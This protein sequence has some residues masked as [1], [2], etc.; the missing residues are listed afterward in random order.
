MQAV[1]S[2]SLPTGVGSG[3]GPVRCCMKLDSG[4]PGASCGTT[5]DEGGGGAR[6]RPRDHFSTSATP[7]SRDPKMSRCLTLFHPPG[8]IR[9]QHGSSLPVQPHGLFPQRPLVPLRRHS[10]NRCRPGETWRGLLRHPPSRSAPPTHRLAWRGPPDSA[11]NHSQS[12][13]RHMEGYRARSG[14]LS[15][16]LHPPGTANWRNSPGRRL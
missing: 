13:P 10:G 16:S 9:R 3:S 14:A 11:Q 4:G 7:A 12:K 2:A 8:P 1:I 6:F 15:A 5:G